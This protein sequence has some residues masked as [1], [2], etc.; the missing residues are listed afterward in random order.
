MS[1]TETKEEFLSSFKSQTL[2]KKVV[3][4]STALSMGVNFPDVK[5]AVNWGPPRTL[6]E[7]H[8]EA[9]ITG[10]NGN[11]AHSIVIYHG[12]QTAHCEADV[13]NFVCTSDCY[14]VASLK[15]FVDNVKP[16]QPGH[17]CCSN[18]ALNCKCETSCSVFSFKSKQPFAGVHVP[19]KK[20]CSLRL[21]VS[22][23]VLISKC[24]IKELKK[25]K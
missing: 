24:S 4:S 6:L 22:T 7:Y 12:N 16:L 13:K 9:G 1:W 15:P 20:I 19:L 3:V 17:N 25:R 23:A 10:W 5:F 2:L 18:C 21:H 11:Q 14:R 8:Q